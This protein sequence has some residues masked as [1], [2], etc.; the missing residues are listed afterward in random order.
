MVFA[1]FTLFEDRG[2]ILHTL[3][4]CFHIWFTINPILSKKNWHQ[5]MFQSIITAFAILRGCGNFLCPQV[6][7]FLIWQGGQLNVFLWISIILGNFAFLKNRG[8]FSS[9][10]AGLAS[11]LLHFQ[12]QPLARPCRKMAL[13]NCHLPNNLCRHLVLR[14]AVRQ[15]PKALGSCCCGYL[16]M[17]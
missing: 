12:T 16:N 15:L 3:T 8:N 1:I 13:G 7:H 5:S 11:F 17:M 4:H 2:N 6:G 14:I 10:Q 9:P